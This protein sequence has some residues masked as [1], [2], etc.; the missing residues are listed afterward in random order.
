MSCDQPLD[1]KTCLVSNHLNCLSEAIPMSTHKI[2]FF[3]FFVKITKKKKKKLLNYCVKKK[4]LMVFWFVVLQISMLSPLL[5]LQ[6]YVFCLKLPEGWSGVAKASCIL[7]HQGVQLILAYSWARP[8]VLAAGM[9]RGGM[10]NFFCVF[11]F[12]HFPLS[13]L[14][15]SFISSTISSI[16]LLP[17]SGRRHK[18]THKHWRV[19]KPQHNQSIDAWSFLK[20]L[21]T[22]LRSAKALVRLSLCPGLPEPLLI[23][24]PMW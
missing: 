22:C 5:E 24:L 17:F 8:A 1:S 7:R 14:S 15:L 6:T 12:I 16:S 10:F 18:M 20:V 9:G 2:F 4:D 3:F 19:V 23:Q 21:T 11:T 13:P